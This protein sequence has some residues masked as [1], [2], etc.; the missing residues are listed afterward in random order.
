MT[1]A[2]AF[3]DFP[4]PGARPSRAI[5]PVL[6]HP[7]TRYFKLE[8]ILL[9]R[10][11]LHENRPDAQDPARRDRARLCGRP[12]ARGRV[13][14][15]AAEPD[16][17]T[18]GWP[19]D[20]PSWDPNQRFVP[21]AQPI[22]K[23]VFDQ[24]L[25][26]DLA[27]ACS[28]RGEVLGARR[29]WQEPSGRASRRRRL[30]Q[31]RQDDDDGFPLHLL[32]EDQGRPQGRY[33][34]LLAQGHRHRD[35]LA[36]ECGDGFDSPAPTAPQWPA[37]LGSY[38]VPKDYMEKTGVD[39]FR[40]KPIGSGPYRIAE[41]QLNARIVLERNDAYW[42]PKAQDAIASPSR[43]SRTPRRASPPSSPARST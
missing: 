2:G 4:D 27:Q 9:R 18:I 21:D 40:D 36:D 5:D 7:A 13:G 28:E 16:S 35:R 30:S 8:T 3:R 24:P 41:Y 33:R 34:E 15:F 43:S 42:G 10:G 14:A 22:F 37:F 39:T 20:V 12:L 38:V 25:D 19:Q 26:Q 6:L 32:R 1:T 23:M 31:R 17:V 29:R 11:S